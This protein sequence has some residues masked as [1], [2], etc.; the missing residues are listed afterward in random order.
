MGL[1]KSMDL[2][3]LLLNIVFISVVNA[4][5]AFGIASQDERRCS[6]GR[7]EKLMRIRC[8]NMDLKEVPQNMKTS[9]EVLDLSY[10]RI[11]KLRSGSFQR[12]TDIKFLML[13]ENMILSV[14]PGTFAPLTSLQE[15]DL[16]NNGLTTIPMELFSLPRL[17]N[18]YIDSNDLWQLHQDIE[19]LERPIRA[20][21][22][23]L[24]MANCELHDI[25]DLG[26]LP[27][28]WQLNV[29]TN[30]LTNFHIEKL[31]NMCHLRVIDLMRTQINS[32]DCQQVTNHLM[33]IGA[34]PK[35]VPVCMD[36]LDSSACPLPYNRTVNSETFRSCLDSVELA[37]T[38]SL[39]LFAAG[40]F[41]GVI[42]VLLVFWYC[43]H[44]WRKR[45]AN[46][47][48]SQSIQ[49]RKHFVISPRNAINNRL[50]DEPLHCDTAS[51]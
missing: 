37:E 30:P 19:T 16:S 23:Y 36:S 33:A 50:E 8:Y 13:Y 45:R 29:S 1:P 47:R 27:N 42:L 14:E 26:I 51:A 34:N 35:F 6:V 46:R 10:N 44:R 28:L 3:Y 24:N 17:R 20:P 49:N 48:L 11:R 4:M 31:A 25:P 9:V 18:L 7:I 15:V 21:L 22:E 41:G 39:W 43:I 40:C 32:C 12:Y 5:L 38:R 2:R